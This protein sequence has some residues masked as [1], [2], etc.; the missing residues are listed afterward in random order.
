MHDR[1]QRTGVFEFF[2]RRLSGS[3]ETSLEQN[4]RA[5][6]AL[7]GWNHGRKDVLEILMPAEMPEAYRRSLASESQ[8]LLFPCS[9]PSQF[10]LLLCMHVLLDFVIYPQKGDMVTARFGK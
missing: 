9:S 2:D 10:E 6:L 4:Q 8:R 5:R 7:G 3:F 1:T